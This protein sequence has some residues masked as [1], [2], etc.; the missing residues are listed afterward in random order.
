ML[1]SQLS[2]PTNGHLACWSNSKLRL[3]WCIGVCIA[4]FK[5]VRSSPTGTCTPCL[6]AFLRPTLVKPPTV[7]LT[8][9]NVVS[10]LR[11]LILFV[12]F[13]FPFL[14][15]ALA[16]TRIKALGP[17]DGPFAF[18]ANVDDATSCFEVVNEVIRVDPA[19]VFVKGVF[20]HCSHAS[21]LKL[22]SLKPSATPSR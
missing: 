13:P 12:F 21:G 5:H 10:A 7:L 15:V 4:S 19:L 16:R 11:L 17:G 8:F 2:V 14:S 9:S 20:L 1:G 18:A 6:R 22:A 3:A